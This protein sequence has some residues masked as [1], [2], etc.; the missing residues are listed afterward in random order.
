MERVRR[1][2]IIRLASP[3]A[4][5]LS[6]P[7]VPRTRVLKMKKAAIRFFPDDVRFTLER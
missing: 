6:I 1:F 7:A 3:A 5:R 4:H 2:V